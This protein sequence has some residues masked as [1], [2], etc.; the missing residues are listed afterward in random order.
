MTFEEAT[1]EAARRNGIQGTVT[2]TWFVFLYWLPTW[3]KSYDVTLVPTKYT[4]QFNGATDS[5]GIAFQRVSIKAFPKQ[6]TATEADFVT[7][8]DAAAANDTELSTYLGL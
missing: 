8:F 7:S 2:N 6:A 1:A 4:E 5:Q 3:E